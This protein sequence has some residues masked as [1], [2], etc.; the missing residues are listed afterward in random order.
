MAWSSIC[1][2]QQR[3]ITPFACTPVMLIV[4]TFY[5]DSQLMKLE[6]SSNTTFLPI[7]ILPTMLPAGEQFSLK[8]AVWNLT[9]K[10]TKE[11]TAQAFLR[12]KSH[13]CLKMFRKLMF[14]ILVSWP[15]PIL[16][17]QISS[18]TSSVVFYQSIHYEKYIY[19]LVRYQF[20]MRKHIYQLVLSEFPVY[21]SCSNRQSLP[22]SSINQFILR[23][24]I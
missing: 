20:I 9:N 13:D 4:Y 12:C 11:R 14:C 21:F 2:S 22:L 18:I 8:D 23:K 3:S 16:R 6:T 24:Y 10:Q 7:R 17:V 5:S 19:R 15:V 1:S